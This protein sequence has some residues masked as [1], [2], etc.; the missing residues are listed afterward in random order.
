MS[1][2]WRWAITIAG[3]LVALG[4]LYGFAVGGFVRPHPPAWLTERPFAHRGYHFE[5]MHPENSLAA[6]R[7][8]VEA[9]YGVELDVHLTADGQV[10]VVHDDS[11]LR[12]TGDRRQVS[13]V[14]IAELRTLRL[15][16]TAEQIPT[17]AEVL[18]VVRGRV[19]VLVEIKNDGPAGPLEVE[20]AH[21]LRAYRGQ[22]A[23]MSFDPLSL[24]ELAKLAPGIPRGQITGLFA[25]SELPGY[26]LFALQHLMLNFLSKPDF[27]VDDLARAPA[28]DVSAQRAMGRKLLLY[29]PA[30]IPDAQR[31]KATAD[32]FIG[33]PGA[34]SGR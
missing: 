3:A 10:V 18:D 14:T 28:W 16:G 19:P 8:A 6:F 5:V 23:V 7:S 24:G 17:L 21:E 20:V 11:L 26:Q 27:I 22:V 31:A 29:A 30:T 15:E 25:E 33:D 13:D 2:G 1:G 4:A 12:T 9:G 32:N 34:F